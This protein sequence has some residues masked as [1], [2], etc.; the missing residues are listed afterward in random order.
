MKKIL[1]YIGIVLLILLPFAVLFVPIGN[2]IIL[3]KYTNKL[4]HVKLNADY[5]VLAK[6][7]E[8]GKLVGNGNGMQYFSALLIH[9]KEPLKWENKH[10]EGIFLVAVNNDSF[11]DF[12]EGYDFGSSC[13]NIKKKLEKI[14]NTENHYVMYSFYNADLDSIWNDDLRAH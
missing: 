12:I 6:D 13:N 14:N 11:N 9:S 1:K 3:D 2:N 7:S 8:C 4:K 10:E 5:E